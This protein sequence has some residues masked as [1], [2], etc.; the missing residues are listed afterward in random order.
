MTS[1]TVRLCWT[2][3]FLDYRCS[4]PSLLTGNNG[5]TVLLWYCY[6]WGKFQLSCLLY[7]LINKQSTPARIDSCQ[8]SITV[9]SI[10]TT[11]AQH[12]NSATPTSISF[13][14]SDTHGTKTLCKILFRNVLWLCF[15]QNCHA[16]LPNNTENLY[17]QRN[18]PSSAARH[19]CHTLYL[20]FVLAA[21]EREA[22]VSKKKRHRPYWDYFLAAARAHN[23]TV[24]LRNS[25]LSITP[26][27][28]NDKAFNK[29]G[30]DT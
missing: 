7:V 27:L 14:L 18:K 17:L 5:S 9:L 16:T 20:S 26:T 15:L 3:P 4:P 21:C 11:N 29:L 23:H 13:A 12:T 6:S 25:A 10:P 22:S 19:G 28:S 24:P 8:M 1:A 30:K 2:S